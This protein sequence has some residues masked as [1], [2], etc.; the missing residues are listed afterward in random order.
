MRKMRIFYE[1]I[2]HL[3]PG[4]D[5]AIWREEVRKVVEEAARTRGKRAVKFT[6]KVN[7]KTH[8]I[9]YLWKGVKKRSARIYFSAIGS[10]DFFVIAELS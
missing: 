9:G 10:K 1:K 4:L 7:D 2:D 5:Q 6:I 3:N 8:T